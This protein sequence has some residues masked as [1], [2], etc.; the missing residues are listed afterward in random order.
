MASLAY[1]DTV[2]NMILVSS[3]MVAKFTAIIDDILATADLTTISEKQIR[4][5]LQASI[6]YDLTEQKVHSPLRPLR[7]LT[8][9]I[10]GQTTPL[11]LLSQ[12]SSP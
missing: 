2:P 1:P 8:I 12:P 10:L 9:S 11:T 4:K 6:D 7:N 3:D 5:G